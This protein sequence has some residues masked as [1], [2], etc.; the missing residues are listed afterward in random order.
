MANNY[1]DMTGVLVLDKVTPVIR[2]L[3]GAL[4]LDE[5]YP[6]NGFAYIANISES[7]SNS[8]CSILEN[9]LELA[10]S[11]KLEV[12]DEDGQPGESMED[13]LS[14]LA[15]HFKVD[16]SIELE[17]LIEHNDF[18]DDA[19]MKSLFMIAKL[20]NDGHGLTAYKTESAWHCSKP[21]LFE[22]GGCGDFTG[23]HVT[24]SGSSNQV[25]SLGEELEASL[26]TGDTDA[27]AE[28]VRTNVS[29]LLAGIY[30]ET[31]RTQ[32]R[33]KLIQLL[34]A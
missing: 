30:D 8:W 26:A 7:T 21:R 1:Y 20:L 4:E 31:V 16:D 23:T 2:A 18:D 33:N 28:L 15:L 12:V 27:A 24:V 13:V 10:D 3:Y 29:E 19:D 17:N 22:F 25:V 11:L 34:Q 32:V 5:N 14:A 6:G 9:L